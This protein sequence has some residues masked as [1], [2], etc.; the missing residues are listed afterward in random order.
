MQ[1]TSELYEKGKQ[2]RIA[3][4][5]EEHVRKALA[6]RQSEFTQPLQLFSTEYAWGRVWSR[7]ELDLR[8]RSLTSMSHHLR[9]SGKIILVFIGPLF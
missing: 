2:V 8:S 4:L 9:K 6:S 1:N 7:P 5:G 3:V